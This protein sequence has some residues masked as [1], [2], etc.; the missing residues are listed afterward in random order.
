MDGYSGL[1]QR[2]S[3]AQ[4]GD[5]VR[6]VSTFAMKQPNA[7]TTEDAAMTSLF[8]VEYQWRGASEKV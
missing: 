3:S 1:G 6:N 8:N 7:F 4:A 5:T 2:G